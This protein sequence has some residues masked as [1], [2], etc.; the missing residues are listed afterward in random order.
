MKTRFSGME[1]KTV[2]RVVPGDLMFHRGVDEFWL[3]L[4]ICRSQ[5]ESGFVPTGRGGHVYTDA[6]YDIVFLAAP[7]NGVPKIQRWSFESE[8][9][10]KVI[11][12]EKCNH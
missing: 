12:H 2:D 9:T 3:V 4:S 8:K 11:S 5:H 1:E 7:T 10:L 6:A